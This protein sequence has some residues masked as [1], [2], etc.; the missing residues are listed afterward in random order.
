MKKI[1]LFVLSDLKNIFR[2]QILTLMFFV[3]AIFYAILKFAVPFLFQYVPETQEY[4]WLI[5]AVICTM[6]AVM[7]AYIFSFIM[8]DEKD[9]R[10]TEIFKIIPFQLKKVVI[11]RLF[12]IGIFSFTS[13]LFLIKFGYSQYISIYSVIAIAFIFS[14][15]TAVGLLAIVSV[16]KD[17][18]VAVTM[19]KGLNVIFMIPAV[20]FLFD[21]KWLNIFQ[22]EPNFWI[23]RIFR[24][25]SFHSNYVNSL[26]VAFVLHTILLVLLFRFYISRSYQ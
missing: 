20:C 16:A 6:V 21:I 22:I 8:L 18:I 19:C 7:P 24:E 14:L 4:E 1:A 26:S 5:V 12:F 10:I 25:M 2:E 11:Y 15:N 3:P 23:F 17:K 13:V 9:E